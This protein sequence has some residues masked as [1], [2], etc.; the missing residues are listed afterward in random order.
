M[1][2]TVL[3]ISLSS[4]QPSLVMPKF[5]TIKNST[6]CSLNINIHHKLLIIVIFQIDLEF[7]D[8]PTKRMCCSLTSDH[9]YT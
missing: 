5:F 2:I 4:H 6:I 1:A 8:S 9:I 3:E 7:R